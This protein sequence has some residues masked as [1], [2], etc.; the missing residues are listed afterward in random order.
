MHAAAMILAWRIT[1]CWACFTTLRL[2][3]LLHLH[4]YTLRVTW[5]RVRNVAAYLRQYRL[6][7]I[8][9]VVSVCIQLI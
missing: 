6:L 3:L 1:H 4:K 2:A 9:S 7:L 5:F 8:T